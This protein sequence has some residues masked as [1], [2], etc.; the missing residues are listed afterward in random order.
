MRFVEIS[1]RGPAT[2]NT[3]IGTLP[4]KTDDIILIGTHTDS[5]FVGALDN[6]AANSGLIIY[7]LF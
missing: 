3:I 4:G 1:K 7:I 2:S 6:A 5:T